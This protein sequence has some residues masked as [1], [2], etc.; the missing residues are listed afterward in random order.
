MATERLLLLA[1]TGFSS[2]SRSASPCTRPRSWGL[3]TRTWAADGSSAERRR[4]PAA[5]AARGAGA[6]P[7]VATSAW[8]H[9]AVGVGT[10]G[11]PRRGPRSCGPTDAE[12]PRGGRARALPSAPEHID[13]IF[14]GAGQYQSLAKSWPNH[15]NHFDFIRYRSELAAQEHIDKGRFQGRMARGNIQK[16]R[17]AAEADVGIA[18]LS[19]PHIDKIFSGSEWRGAIQ[20]LHQNHATSLEPTE[21]STELQL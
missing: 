11:H 17:A 4:G 12:R 13:K 9:V 5:C 6:A 14:S 21:P 16:S 2:S 10:S 20:S 7:K 15:S 18:A 19:E 3:R 1:P 8:P